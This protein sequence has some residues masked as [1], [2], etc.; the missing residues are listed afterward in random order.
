MAG[1]GTRAAGAEVGPGGAHGVWPGRGRAGAAGAA[2]PWTGLRRGRHG[3]GRGGRGRTGRGAMA[4][5]REGGGEEREEGGAAAVRRGGRRR[6]RAGEGR[7][8]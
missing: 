8:G 3:R 5:E 2:A 4:G 7:R 1:A 6:R